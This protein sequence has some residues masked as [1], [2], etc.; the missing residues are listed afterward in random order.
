MSTP[1]P[2]SMPQRQPRRT[3]RPPVNV[4]QPV[5]PPAPQP[6]ADNAKTRRARRNGGERY[7]KEVTP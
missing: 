1:T 4:P 6:S 7:V 2:A 5:T 3:W